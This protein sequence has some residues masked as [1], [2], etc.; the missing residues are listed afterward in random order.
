MD[1]KE[2]L[3]SSTKIAL[4][5]LDKVI[6]QVIDLTQLDVEKAKI[7]A[8]GKVEAIKSSMELMDIIE[9]LESTDE[10]TYEQDKNESKEKNKPFAGP[11]SKY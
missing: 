3:L 9:K 4:D 6:N 2:R 11:E 5:E 1:Y 10:E 8:Q 7:A